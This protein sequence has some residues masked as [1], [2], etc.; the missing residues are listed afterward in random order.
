MKLTIHLHLAPRLRSRGI[1]PPLPYLFM[2]WCLVKHRIRV[3][4][5]VLS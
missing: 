4:D 5:V 1:M 2:A 3:R